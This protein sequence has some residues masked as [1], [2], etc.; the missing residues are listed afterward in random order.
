MRYLRISGRSMIH[1]ERKG[2][3][4][5][6]C[7]RYGGVRTDRHAHDKVCAKCLEYEAAA[8]RRVDS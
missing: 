5:T 1:I 3:N 6:F 2:W 7:G 8:R 4:A